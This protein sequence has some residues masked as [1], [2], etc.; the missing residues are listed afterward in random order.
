M[1]SQFSLSQDTLTGTGFAGPL[2][3]F[4]IRSAS[5]RSYLI[6]A[7]GQPSDLFDV[8]APN[9]FT[10][11]RVMD[12]TTPSSATLF[13]PHTP[14][15]GIRRHNNLDD[16]DG[17]NFIADVDYKLEPNDST[18]TGYYLIVFVL[19]SNNGIAAYRSKLPVIVPVDLT[20]CQAVL[21]ER[22]I[23]LSWS[24]ASEHNNAGFEVQRS[25]SLG[26]EWE[27]VGFVKGQGTTSITGMYAFDDPLTRTHRDVGR[28]QYRLRQV[29]VDGSSSFSPVAEV[30]VTPSPAAVDL[31]Q[32]FP[33][34]VTDHTTVAFYIDRE[35]PV[36]LRLLN[37][38]GEQVRVLSEG[39]RA[40]GAHTV[41]LSA[42]ML[43][44]GMYIVELSADGSLRQRCMQVL[45]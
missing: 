15:M 14:I 5:N 4:T 40:P 13:L 28:V 16:M 27:A 10:T 21:R 20:A 22:H 39:T 12:V 17:Y 34:P 41:D 37:M 32:N 3:F 33:N 7:D 24:V 8:N 43:P 30:Y 11:A 19:M 35:M 18:G 29:D 44:S 1:V 6:C 36:R 31:A 38:I 45:H 25:F 42:E 9:Y 2:A 23:H 26:R